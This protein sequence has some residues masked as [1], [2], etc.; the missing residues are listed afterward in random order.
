MPSSHHIAAGET[1]TVSLYTYDFDLCSNLSAAINYKI[2]EAHSTSVYSDS[3]DDNNNPAS[4]YEITV[5]YDTNSSE[6]Y[7][8]VSYYDLSTKEYVGLT[9]SGKGNDTILT[10]G[11]NRVG[12]FWRA[13]GKGV[14]KGFCAKL[15]PVYNAT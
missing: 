14:S 10:T 12:L 8:I 3:Y 2:G 13:F 5:Y 7:V 6:D 4:G 11:G 9:F 1:S 15:T